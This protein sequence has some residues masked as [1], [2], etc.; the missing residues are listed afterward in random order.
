MGSIRWA[1]VLAF[2]AFVQVG[3]EGRPSLVPPPEAF[4]FTGRFAC[5]CAHCFG[6]LFCGDPDDPT[7]VA[8]PDPMTGD[9]PDGLTLAQPATRLLDTGFEPFFCVPDR[10]DD[11]L[12]TGGTCPTEGSFESALARRVEACEDVPQCARKP[13]DPFGRYTRCRDEIAAPGEV[14]PGGPTGLNEKFTAPG[15]TVCR[16]FPSGT[17]R[18]DAARDVQEDAV[19]VCGHFHGEDIRS[20]P[21]PRR[22]CFLSCLDTSPGPLCDET[23]FDPP[24]V[25][26]NGALLLRVG[27]NPSTGGR[28]RATVTLGT[29][30]DSVDVEGIV[31]LS[32]PGC[33]PGVTC[34]ARISFLELRGLGT[35]NI[36]GATIDNLVVL[37]AQPLED[38]MFPIGPTRSGL[39]IDAGG[40]VFATAD[41]SDL[42]GRRGGELRLATALVGILDWGTHSFELITTLVD[43]DPMAE[44]SLSLTLVGE[45][46]SIQPRADAGA[47]Q[48]VECT[49]PAGA[50]VGLSGAGSTDPDDDLVRHSWI[51]EHTF[52][53]SAD[54]TFTTEL[55]RGPH[56]FVLTVMDD[57]G[58]ADVDRVDVDIIDTRGP[59]FDRVDL[60]TDCLWPPDHSMH[61][62]RLG[63]ELV[64]EATDVCEAGPST[65]RIIDVRS[66][67]PADTTKDGATSPD[68][69]FGEAA[70]CLRGERR[71]DSPS[72]RPRS[73]TVVLAANDSLGNVTT[74]EVEIRVPHDQ[75][76]SDRCL[77]GGLAPAVADDDPRCVASL[78]RVVAT[79]ATIP[80]TGAAGCS[81]SRVPQHRGIVLALA[82]LALLV[83]LGR[84]SRQR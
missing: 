79:P 31:W 40:V 83:P 69:L 75:R 53:V 36:A 17:S 26:P 18:A 39:I 62:F 61:L 71:G 16:D 37:N 81:V 41:I 58:Q 5:M 52:G 72:R 56:H 78:P 28:A 65:V 48:V 9:C 49:S 67:Q 4:G 70:F 68:V 12:G 24:F 42:S 43:P 10:G 19:E 21:A 22:Y 76:P 34:Q 32:A 13:D 60:A 54:V 33:G 80:S 25:D 47:D 35:L 57:V 46:P 11:I 66:D 38:S 14:C 3:C 7:R 8:P 23:I 6:T 73:Y 51:N 30:S 59:S 82:A 44:L 74:R 2:L 55:A 45:I 15:S 63:R 64:A 27:T 1:G 20:A 50:T 84:R 29:D 77:T